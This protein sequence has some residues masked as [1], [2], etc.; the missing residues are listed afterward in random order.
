LLLAARDERGGGFTH[1]ELREEIITLLLAGHET[2]AL[3]IAYTLM[4]LGWNADA[5]QSLQD[6]VDAKFQGAV[7]QTRDMRDVPMIDAAVHESLRMYPPAAVMTRQAT[8]EEQLGPYTIPQNAQVMIPIRAIHYDPRW[9]PNPERFDLSRWTREAQKSR[10]RYSFV[11]F[12]GGHRVCIGEHF[13]RLESQVV[14]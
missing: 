5:T 3:H 9:Y 14:L 8:Q 4:L 10:P 7:P 1:E 6:E 13:A 11:P 12:G 2:T